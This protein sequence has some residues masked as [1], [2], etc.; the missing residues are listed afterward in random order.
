MDPVNAVRLAAECRDARPAECAA[1][2]TRREVDER[3]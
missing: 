2:H 3:A 1:P